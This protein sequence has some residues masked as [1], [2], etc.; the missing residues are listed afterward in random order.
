MCIQG[1][2]GVTVCPDM[3]QLLA[4]FMIHPFLPLLFLHSHDV[5]LM[6]WSR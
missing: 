5:T 2:W 1:K 6:I 3:T 4:V